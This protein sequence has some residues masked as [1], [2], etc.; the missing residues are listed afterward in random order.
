MD[1]DGYQQTPGEKIFL[2]HLSSSSSSTDSISQE[3][4]NGMTE[5]KLINVHGVS[6]GEELWKIHC[7]RSQGIDFE[8]DEEVKCPMPNKKTKHLESPGHR[9]ST[10]GA[11]KVL[12]LRTRDVKIH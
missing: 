11:D 6:I 10:R 1:N 3:E 5:M 8:G 2:E 4:G 9:I 7:K 12:T